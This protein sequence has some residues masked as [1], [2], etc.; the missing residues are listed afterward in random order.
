MLSIINIVCV[1]NILF[2]A[3]KCLNLN[4]FELFILHIYNK[5]TGYQHTKK[6]NLKLIPFNNMLIRRAKKVA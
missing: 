6:H 4:T 3:D 2:T 1:T 5:F